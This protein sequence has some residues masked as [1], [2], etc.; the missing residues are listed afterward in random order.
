MAK[1]K[2]Q[3]SHPIDE[4]L[5]QDSETGLRSLMMK[6]SESKNR[7]PMLEVIFDRLI[8]LLSGSY[9][10]FT[11]YTVDVEIESQ[12]TLTFGDF[13]AKMPNPSMIGIVR[14]IEWDNL[15][16]VTV[17]S[18]L[19]YALID[20]LFGGRKSEGAIRVEGRAYTTIEQGIVQGV[21]ELLLNDLSI[22]FESITPITFQMDRLESN[23]KFAVISRPDDMVH[24]LRLSVKMESRSGIIELAIP[25]STIEPVKKVLQRSFLG[26]RGTR[27]PAWIKQI[28]SEISSAHVEIEA[29]LN[30]VTS[31]VKDLMSLKVGHTVVLDKEPDDDILVMIGKL[32][33]SSGKIGKV[34]SRVA[35]KLS[36]HINLKHYEE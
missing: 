35:I 33:V 13:I 29:R 15:L 31:T 36:E 27:D 6:N 14:A 7:L 28:H 8:R 1:E 2:E 25:Y 32:R 20:I 3:E 5:E 19:V 30:G 21:T 34:D 9:R 17:D 11:S 4:I 24:L 18:G 16:L 26:E 23:P 10:V 12:Q 22:S